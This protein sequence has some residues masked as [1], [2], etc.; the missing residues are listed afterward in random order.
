MLSFY[1]LFI[2]ASQLFNL[3]YLYNGLDISI[4]FKVIDN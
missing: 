3:T 4:I 2:I 1:S